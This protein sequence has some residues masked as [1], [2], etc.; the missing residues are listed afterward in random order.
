MCKLLILQSHSPSERDA[1]IAKAWSY[2]RSSGE[3]DGYGAL[4]ISRAGELAWRKS[5]H[6]ALKGRLPAW[7]D[8]FAASGGDCRSPSN[9]GWLMMHG[10]TATCGVNLTNTHPMLDDQGGLVHNGVV[11]SEV[12]ANVSTSCDSELILRAWLQAS[13]K[14][15]AHLSGYF[16]FGGLFRHPEGWEAVIAR[17]DQ[18]RLRVGRSKQ[19]W[20]WGTTDDALSCAGVVPLKLDHKPMTGLA[21]TPERRQPRQFSF[22][23]AR[24]LAKQKD[25]ELGWARASGGARR[26]ESRA[27]SALWSDAA[28]GSPTDGVD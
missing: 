9:G 19:G 16:A 10:R 7:V 11:A 13:D 17:D 5:S 22:T 15:L 23:K 20:A 25:L 2:F 21:F 26:W 8:A 12:V 14:G 4:W 28:G 3:D 24:A 1:I 6:P 18:A 27:A